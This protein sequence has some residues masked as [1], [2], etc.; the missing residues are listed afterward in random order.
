MRINLGAGTSAKYYPDHV[1]VDFI[2][3]EGIDV[4]HNLNK[5]P[6]PFKDNSADQI[7]A[8]DVIEHL[9][10]HL[11]DIPTMLLFM[12]EAHRILKKGGELYLTTPHWQSR[13]L[14]IDFTHVRGFD[15]RSFDY[16]DP[17][18]DLG[19]DYGY[20]SKCKF[21]VKATRTPNDNVEFRMIKL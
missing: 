8:I 7:Q 3:S 12:E 4:V 15:E 11:D 21:T 9:P 6:W 13:N 1:N 14:W 20:Y 17:S 19:K 10:S 5:F 2:D 16:F 18:T